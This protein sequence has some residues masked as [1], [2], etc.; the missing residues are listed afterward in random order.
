MSRTPRRSPGPRQRDAAGSG[1]EANQ[2]AVVAIKA[3][4]TLAWLSIE[5]CVVYLLITGLAGRTDKRAGLA[6]AVV[7][8][9]TLVFAG[10]GFRCPLTGLAKR[11]GAESGS[12]TD[13]Y[14][15]RWFA[16]NL[17][18]IHTP[19]LVLMA[20]FHLKNLRRQRASGF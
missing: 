7:T 12:V 8:T 9:E 17:P 3:V 20:Y 6:A 14:L 18:A 13:I 5:S 16:H 10:N 19:L 15:P 11:Y 1:T 4:H 2:A